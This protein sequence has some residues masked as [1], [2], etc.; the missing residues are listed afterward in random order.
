MNYSNAD[1][2]NQSFICKWDDLVSQQKHRLNNAFVYVMS[3]SAFQGWIQ[4]LC[5]AILS[6]T[7]WNLLPSSVN[8]AQ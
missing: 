1:L 4:R 2:K 5:I 3:P 6:T 7:S 8:E